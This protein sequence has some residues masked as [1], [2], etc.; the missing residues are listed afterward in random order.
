[1]IQRDSDPNGMAAAVRRDEKL[2]AKKVGDD[3]SLPSFNAAEPGPS[4]ADRAASTLRGAAAYRVGTPLSAR[5]SELAIGGKLKRYGEMAQDMMNPDR[6]GNLL[7][8]AMGTKT[9][10]SGDGIGSQPVDDRSGREGIKATPTTSQG[11]ENVNQGMDAQRMS[12]MFGPARKP[13]EA[14]EMGNDRM[15]AQ[16]IEMDEPKFGAADFDLSKERGP[17]DSFSVKAADFKM[18]GGG[19]RDNA[20]SAS[21]AQGG[22]LGAAPVKKKGGWFSRGMKAFGRGLRDNFMGGAFAPKVPKPTPT[23]APKATI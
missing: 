17:G 22:E 2:R 7:G 3:P 1:M 4:F 5:A 13:F 9:G 20:M 8:A 15:N 10:G 12:P 19:D 6:M 16:A 23:M 11:D 21:K 14:P 18:G